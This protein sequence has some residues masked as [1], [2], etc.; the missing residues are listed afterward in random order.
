MTCSPA[1]ARSPAPG[2]RS[3]IRRAGLEATP[4]FHRRATRRIRPGPTPHSGSCAKVGRL[5][6]SQ[7]HLTPWQM[8]G[9]RM[10]ASKHACHA[11]SRRLTRPCTRAVKTPERPDTVISSSSKILTRPTYV[12][13]GV[14]AAPGAAPLPV[15][16]RPLAVLV[17]ADPVDRFGVA[18]QRGAPAAASRSRQAAV[19]SA[20]PNPPV[21]VGAAPGGW[22]SQGVQGPNTYLASYSR[23]PVRRAAAAVYVTKERE[24]GR[25]WR[26]GRSSGPGPGPGARGRTRYTRGAE[27]DP[28]NPAKPAAP[29]LTSTNAGWRRFFKPRRR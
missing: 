11:V 14:T 28:A 22:S 19:S 2:R 18:P 24:T 4:R 8:R 15:L 7:Q 27:S 6:M 16:C 23:R 5:L 21:R 26:G 12:T 17:A 20:L 1:P 9:V 10:Q 3:P 25:P 29:M 13:L